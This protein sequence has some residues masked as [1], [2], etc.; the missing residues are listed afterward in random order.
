MRDAVRWL[1]VLAIA[2]AFSLSSASAE[3]TTGTC[4]ILERW[5]E[6]KASSRGHAGQ[7]VRIREAS[8]NLG[9]VNYRVKYNIIADPAHPD[10]VEPVEGYIGMPAPSPENW[11][12]NGFLFIAVNGHDLGT[13]PLSSM[14]VSEQGKRGM[15]D[16]VWHHPIASVR[17]RF[18]GL[19]GDD[20]LMVEIAIEPHQDIRSITVQARCYPSF[21]TTWYHRKGARRVKTPSKLI[22]EGQTVT[23]EPTANWWLLYY[24]EVFDVAKGE[25]VGPCAMAFLPDEAEAVKVRVSD[26]AVDTTIRYGPS[27]RRI[28]LAF[29][30]MRGSKNADALAAFP[31][32]AQ[33]A[34]EHL[35]GVDFTPQIIRSFDFGKR[36]RE[37]QE[38][39]Q[40][41]DVPDEL[42]AALGEQ[43]S[44]L[45]RAEAA[46]KSHAEL[47]ITAEEELLKSMATY[48]SAYWELKLHRLLDF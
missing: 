4:V 42:Q 38:L 17:A 33:K 6:W 2:I 44:A 39:L 27:A 9:T 16:M 41:P 12:D 36:V 11:Y 48:E 29:W 1:I 25:G 37:V 10:Q 13:V 40:T 20:K 14:V 19:C 31:Q 7:V 46:R 26:Y 43:I 47:D 34:R 18:A 5:K 35:V 23:L 30:D 32:K 28:R 3:D 21:F 15:V 8:F 22:Q 24:D 45:K